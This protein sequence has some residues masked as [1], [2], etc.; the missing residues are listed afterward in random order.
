MTRMFSI[1]AIVAS[2]CAHTGPV[3]PI[4]AE[5]TGSV[6][7][8]VT[9]ARTEPA[10]PSTNRKRNLLF[11]RMLK[12]LARSPAEIRQVIKANI[13]RITSCY[14]VVLRSTPGLEGTVRTNFLIDAGGGVSRAT[15]VGVHPV[16][17]GC[18]AGVIGS[19]QFRP[20]IHGAEV[21]YPFTFRPV[22]DG[23]PEAPPAG[24]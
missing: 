11:L 1:A 18:V 16:V 13:G 3:T 7:P 5:P 12:D 4:P 20:A 15:A 19:L 17:D 23:E 6:A 24:E 2:G 21:N 10:A 22:D 8:A 14:E 9:G